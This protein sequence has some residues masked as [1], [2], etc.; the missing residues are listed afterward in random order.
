[1]VKGAI[2]Q[3]LLSIYQLELQ[4]RAVDA[5]SALRITAKV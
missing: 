1:M 5:A 2:A 4:Q 3:A